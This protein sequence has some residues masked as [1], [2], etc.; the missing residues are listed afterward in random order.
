MDSRER[1]LLCGKHHSGDTLPMSKDLTS[2][3]FERAPFAPRRDFHERV[4]PSFAEMLIF[5]HT[6]M[7]DGFGEQCILS[8]R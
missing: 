7:F 5:I 8:W 2:N 4:G 3:P 6:G 1:K